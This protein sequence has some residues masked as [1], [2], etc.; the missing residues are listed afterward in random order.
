[1]IFRRSPNNGSLLIIEVVDLSRDCWFGSVARK[2]GPLLC[3]LNA[4]IWRSLTSS[5]G[6]GGKPKGLLDFYCFD[7]SVHLRRDGIITAL[8][9]GCIRLLGVINQS[10]F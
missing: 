2:M 1:M 8:A 3:V 6:E 5:C 10:I 9:C 7:L 4:A